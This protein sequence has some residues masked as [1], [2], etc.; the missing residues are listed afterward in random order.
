MARVEL[1][2]NVDAGQSW[3][4]ITAGQEANGRIAERWL[5][6]SCGFAMDDFWAML[7]CLSPA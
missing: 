3:V 6:L 7:G 1:P 2:M 5:C 4:N